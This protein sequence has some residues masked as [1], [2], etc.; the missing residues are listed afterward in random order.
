MFPGYL[1]LQHGMDPRSYTEVRSARGLIKI[2]GR[3]WDQLA[4]VPDAEMEAIRKVHESHL[5]VHA[6]PYLREGQRVRITDGV[7]AGTE[8]VLKRIRLNKGLLVLSI[9]ILQRS[10][11][12]EVDCTL[13]VAA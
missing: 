1:F 12:V 11:A 4:I 2:L 7:L 13:V 9:D 3:A 5:P 8:G 6:H 10:V